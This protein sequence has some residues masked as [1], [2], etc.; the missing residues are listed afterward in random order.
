MDTPKLSLR[1][2][3]GRGEKETKQ[4]VDI[5]IVSN[6]NNR[7]EGETYQHWGLRVCAIANGS[8]YTL[9]PY[10]HNVYNYIRR[11]QLENEDLQNQ[12]RRNLECQIEHNRNN[13]E[14]LNKKLNECKQTQTE[15]KNLI[16][17]LKDEK[18]ALKNKAYEV[19]KEAKIKLILGIVILVPLTLYLFLFY[20]STFYS[21][22]FKQWGGDSS[23]SVFNSMFDPHA[24]SMAFDTSVTELCFV[25]S[26]PV[27][28]LGLGFSL[29]F[30][31]IQKERTKYFKMASVLCITFI[32]DAILAYMIGKHLHE[33]EIIIGSK[34]LGSIYGFHEALTDINTWAV[35]F[36][37]FIV[38]II[39]G[40]VFDM[41]MTAYNQLDL[42]K[43]N[44][45]M[46]DKKIQELYLQINED[47]QQEKTLNDRINECNNNISSLTA[48][49]SNL[50]TFI[51]KGSIRTEMTNFFSG[52]AAQMSVLGK[53]DD[54]QS[55]ANNT[56]EKTLNI[57]LP[58]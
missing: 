9:V 57:L 21:A 24:L 22:F 29:H 36:C 38:Y 23:L 45:R 11:E 54:E 18:T 15:N 28:F 46:I 41:S 39:W 34:P 42:N 35:I 44:S 56:F 55:E 5:P 2:L 47:K 26:A 12:V 20:S 40:I 10:L 17:K 3:F 8:S 31:S 13:I 58:V 51:D 19:N 49:I 27:I 43:I 33:M 7:Q 30:F 52:W 1:S 37:G 48:Q 25:L 53:S 4:Q 14:N 50:D 16:N 32:F 6:P